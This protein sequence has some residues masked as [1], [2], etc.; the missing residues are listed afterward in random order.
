MTVPQQPHHCSLPSCT[1]LFARATAVMRAR[2]IARLL[3]GLRTR[4]T[5]I[6]APAGFGKSTLLAQGLA[7]R[8]E[9]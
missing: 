2:L 1:S 5:L 8:T 4:L 3:S 9:D 6:A 7:A